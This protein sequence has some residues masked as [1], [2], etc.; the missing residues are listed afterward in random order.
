MGFFRRK[1]IAISVHVLLLMG[2]QKYSLGRNILPCAS[3]VQLKDIFR[4]L[5]TRLPAARKV[6]NELVSFKS[7]NVENL[8]FPPQ[9]KSTFPKTLTCFK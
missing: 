8:N 3:C 9:C 2:F 4:L 6:K 7:G 5:P 1:I